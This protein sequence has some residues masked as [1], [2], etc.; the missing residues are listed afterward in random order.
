VLDLENESN[1]HRLSQVTIR[2]RINFNQESMPIRQVGSFARI[3]SKSAQSHDAPYWLM[4][5]R[6]GIKVAKARLDWC[7]ETLA[8][9]KKMAKA[10]KL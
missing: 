1:C 9:L 2:L 5:V 4:T 7:D 6:H 8:R 3:K 10:N